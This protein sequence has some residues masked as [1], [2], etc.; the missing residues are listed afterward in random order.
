VRRNV[1]R[2]LAGAGA[3]ILAAVTGACTRETG[4]SEAPSTCV[5]V[6]GSVDGQSASAA[7]GT[8]DGGIRVTERGFSQLGPNKT[9]VG[10]GAILQ[11]TSTGKVAYRVRV[12]FRVTGADG[13]SAVPAGS[14][15]LL[16]QEIPVIMPQQ[17]VPVGAWTYVEGTVTE[18]TVEVGN[19]SWLPKSDAIAGVDASFKTLERTVSD[20]ETAAV[21][22][23]VTSRYCKDLTP[24]GA[25]MVFRNASGAIVGGSFE[26]GGEKCPPGV[27]TQRSTASR[28]VP[29]DIDVSKTQA[30]PYCDFAAPQ[31]T[32]GGPIN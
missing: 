7:T 3:V 26:L 14:G 13:K 27:S 2:L 31:K 24:R 25:G 28:S 16:V 8:G 18:A 10:V 5:N 9:V 30:Y 12:T 23:T 21:T 29:A 11:N 32:V 4:G 15:E 22:Y 19:V 20:P 6:P 17:S 1:R